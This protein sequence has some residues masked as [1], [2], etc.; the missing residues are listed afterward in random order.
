[1]T[2][3][4]VTVISSRSESCVADAPCAHAV[5]LQHKVAPTRAAIETLIR[6]F[7]D[8]PFPP[9]FINLTIGAV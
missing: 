5:P 8:I 4:P 1:M 6:L 7:A 9:P 2:R 3:D